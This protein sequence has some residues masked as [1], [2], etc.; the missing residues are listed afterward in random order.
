M[1]QV[2]Q[3]RTRVCVNLTKKVRKL[4]LKNLLKNVEFSSDFNIEDI[5]IN[6][7]SYDSRK[8]TKN[9]VF[10][11]LKGTN[12]DGHNF[13]RNAVEKGAA[14]IISQK[15]LPDCNVPVIVVQNTREALA[16]M[17]CEFFGNPAQKLKTI[18][19]TGTKGKTTTACM[20]KAILEEAGTKCGTIG[21][22]GAIVDDEVIKTNNTTPESYEVQKYL[23]LMVEK[24]CK[25][26]V[27]EVSSI[28]LREHRVDGFAFDYGI[29]T[30]FS[31]DHIGENEHKDLQEYLKCKAI[32]FKKCKIGILNKDDKNSENLLKEHN[33]E[34]FFYGFSPEADLFVQSFEKFSCDGVLGTKFTIS[35]KINC[36]ILLK[37][38]GEFNAYNALAAAF[39]CTF[40]GA[41]EIDVRNALAKIKVKGRIECLDVPGNYTLLIDY[42]HNAVSMENLLKTLRE[43]APSRLMVLFGAGGNRPKIRRYE[44]GEV[45]GDLADLVIVTEDNSRNEPVLDI[46]AD[47]ETGL[48]R[49]SGNYIVIPDRREAIKFCLATAQDGDIIVFAGKGHE[50]YQEINGIKLKLDEREIVREYFSEIANTR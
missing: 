16:Y 49:A 22:L 43:Y 8:V 5:D 45:A 29:F 25:V 1:Q 44:M 10:I 37:N 38:P 33:C 13:Y 20:I 17:S 23:K 15:K 36:E 9:N 47:I 11:C 35:G 30:N 41:S 40:L 50:D 12:F 19:I 34:T 28:G 14:A 27:M 3:N 31:S 18:G 46:I 48:K 42:A 26:A 24:G 7:I 6:D 4:L 32:L 21:T 39:V 2:E